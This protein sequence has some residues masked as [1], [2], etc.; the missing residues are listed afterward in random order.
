[1]GNRRGRDELDRVL[2]GVI[3]GREPGATD[4]LAPY[5]HPARVVRAS[6]AR[7]LDPSVARQHLTSLREDRVRNIVVPDVRRRGLRITAVALVGAI[8]LM[9]GAGSAVAASTNALP[10]DPLYGLKRAVER[11]SFAMHRSPGSRASLCL[12]FAQTRLEE[13]QTL[14][15]SGQDASDVVEAFQDDITCAESE[16]ENAVALGQDEE[17]LLAHVQDMIGKHVDVLNDLL[18]GELGNVPD[19]AKDA[20]QR[21]IDNAQKAQDKVEDARSHANG[22]GKPDE[23]PGKGGN[24]PGR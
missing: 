3:A 19:Q 17:V 14:V 8:V 22:H 21:A 16:A 15:G 9:L 12:Q 10:G 6:L 11:I 18:N 7:S 1:M 20:I 23:A 13:V 24:A 2:D 4:D 5:L